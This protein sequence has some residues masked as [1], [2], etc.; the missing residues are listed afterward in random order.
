MILET[1]LAN[2][3]QR[4]WLIYGRNLKG[5]APGH[6]LCRKI[7]FLCSSFRPGKCRDNTRRQATNSFFH[8]LSNSLISCTTESAESA[9]PLCSAIPVL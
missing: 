3:R 9:V 6:R 8:I 2:K 7:Y 5:V 1:F 4:F